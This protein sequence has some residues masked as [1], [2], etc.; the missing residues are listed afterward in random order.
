MK[1][2]VI[3][4]ELGMQE[5]EWTPYLRRTNEPKFSC[6]LAMLDREGIKYRLT[7]ESFHAPIVEVA[8]EHANTAGSFLLP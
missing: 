5:C 3:A 4:M 2:R 6:I 1:R 8:R 7:G